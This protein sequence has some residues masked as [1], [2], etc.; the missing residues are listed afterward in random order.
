MR[1]ETV[2]II[3]IIDSPFLPDK[4][5]SAE[6]DM[7][8]SHWSS[9]DVTG[10]RSLMFLSSQNDD[11]QRTPVRRQNKSAS[12]KNLSRS[13]SQILNEEFGED[14]NNVEVGRATEAIRRLPSIHSELISVTV[15]E[16]D[17]EVFVRSLVVEEEV[18]EAAATEKVKKNRLF[19]PTHS[20]HVSDSMYRTDSGFNDEDLTSNSA[21]SGNPSF[22]TPSGKLPRER[23]GLA[24]MNQDDVSMR[25][26][27][28]CD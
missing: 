14:E 23:L 5:N 15:A 2:G 9:C 20:V 8:V 28:Q 4:D 17:D 26:L 7:H 13:F 22:S 12:R 16:D 21:R 10:N 27:T 1:T 24:M 25:S 19:V 6:S 18:I 11:L 3:I